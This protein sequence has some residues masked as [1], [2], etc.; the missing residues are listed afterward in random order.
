MMELKIKPDQRIW[1]RKGYK[2]MYASNLGSKPAVK[3]TRGACKRGCIPDLLFAG[4]MELVL[5]G[6]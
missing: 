2:T 6:E 4:R 1:P 3:A 5:L